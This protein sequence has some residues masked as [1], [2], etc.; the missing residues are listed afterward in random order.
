MNMYRKTL[1]VSNDDHPI[2]NQGSDPEFVY[3]NDAYKNITVSRFGK[4]EPPKSRSPIKID[5]DEEIKELKS[6]FY[7][8]QMNIDST[9]QV[10]NIKLTTR[11]KISSNL[12]QIGTLSAAKKQ[13]SKRLT[14]LNFNKVLV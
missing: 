7:A 6:S 4:S 3:N 10:S 5:G 2:N 9:E 13:I 14:S 8:T 12:L 11:S 1:N